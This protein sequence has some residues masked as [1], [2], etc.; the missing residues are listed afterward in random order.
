MLIH[1]QKSL[2]KIPDD[3]AAPSILVR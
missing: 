1:I 3:V 2:M